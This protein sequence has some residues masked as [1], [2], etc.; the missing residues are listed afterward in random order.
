[1]SAPIK[2]KCPY[3]D[4][5]AMSPG[6]VRFHVASE[7]PEKVQEFQKDYYPAMLKEFKK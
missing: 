3:C 4:R 7:H 6:G 5:T 1:M 2:Y